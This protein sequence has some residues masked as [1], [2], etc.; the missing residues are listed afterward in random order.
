MPAITYSE[1]CEP[2]WSDKLWKLNLLSY[3]GTTACLMAYLHLNL[4]L[5]ELPVYVH[6]ADDVQNI[7]LGHAAA[8]IS[9]F[10]GHTLRPHFAEI[11]TLNSF[12]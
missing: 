6:G 3:Q 10:L 7:L 4:E 5:R 12:L 1:F 9:P 8:F 11:T 2:E